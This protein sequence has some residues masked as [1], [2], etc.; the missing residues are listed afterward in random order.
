[1]A[2]RNKFSNLVEKMSPER[3]ARVDRLAEAMFQEM[4]LAQL[5]KAR[6]LSQA[7]LGE[8]LHVEQPAVAKLEK[9]AD[10]YVS[11]LRHFIEAMGGELDVV[12]RFPDHAVHITNFHDL[13]GPETVTDN[14]T[15][16]V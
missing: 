7:S 12:A 6:R 8:I 14:Q 2:G 5:R 1:M 16:V 11:T 9:R 4:N 15:E 13:E 3:R 10:M